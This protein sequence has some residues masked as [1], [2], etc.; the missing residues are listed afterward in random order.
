[1]VRRDLGAH[2]HARRLGRPQHGDR[3]R[4]GDVADV[5]PRARPPWPARSRGPRSS[6]RRW[7]ASPRAPAATRPRPSCA[8]APPVS[9]WSSAC[10]AITTSSAVAYSSAL[11]MISGSCTQRPS[12]ENIRTCAGERAIVPS[13]AIRSPRS[14]TVTAPTGC[15]S[16]SPTSAPRRRTCSA[17]TS[18]STTGVGVGHREHGGEPAERRRGRARRDRLGLLAARLAQVGV[19]VD[20][21]RQQ[22]EPVGV[23]RLVG[24]E[25]G[26][27]LRHH[28]VAHQ[29]VDRLALAVRPGTGDHQAHSGAPARRW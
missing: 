13:S 1:M 3:V 10:W 23:E 29:D 6:P 14:P 19:Q 18:V 9:R 15:T 2:P 20:E 26:P 24:G 25:P 16:T 22:H 17:T 7:R 28:A 4:A 21:P 11:R 8:C 5:Q 27:D 12:S